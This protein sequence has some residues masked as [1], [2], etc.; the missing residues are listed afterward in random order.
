MSLSSRAKLLESQIMIMR[1]NTNTRMV[2]FSAADFE[3]LKLNLL[4]PY[5]RRN[6]KDS[7]MWK[8]V[9]IIKV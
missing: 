8:D 4:S 5:M 7:F 6:V 3:L 9:E 2:K 1:N